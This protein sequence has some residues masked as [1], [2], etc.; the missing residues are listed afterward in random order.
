VFPP[1]VPEDVG[2][3]GARFMDV[4]FQQGQGTELF[5]CIFEGA[6][7]ARQYG[8]V[9]DLTAF[10]T[11]IVVNTDAGP[12]AIILWRLGQGPETLVHYEHYLDPLDEPT[13]QMLESIENQSRLKIVM[14][15]NRSGETEGF[16][17][18]DN[19][20]AMGQFAERLVEECRGMYAGPFEQR[21]DLVKRNYGVKDLI[22]LAEQRN[23]RSRSGRE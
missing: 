9:R 22:D 19:V 7:W 15:D 8:S 2:A 18:F 5:L 21:V 16:W 4:E 6:P 1:L 10:A 14:L 13:R 20:F 11:P 17:E 3:T 12:I 23:D